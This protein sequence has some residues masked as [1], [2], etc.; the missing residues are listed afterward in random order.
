MTSLLCRGPGQSYVDEIWQ[1]GA[2]LRADCGDMVK[3]ETG[4][5]IQIWQTFVLQSGNSYISAVD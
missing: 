4:T 1:T 2:E 5:G 3:I